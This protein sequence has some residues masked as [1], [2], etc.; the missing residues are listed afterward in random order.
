MALYKSARSISD[1]KL[2]E[3][4]ETYMPVVPTTGATEL[5]LM[6]WGPYSTAIVW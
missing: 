3:F 5:N 1:M 2:K 4:W 6:P